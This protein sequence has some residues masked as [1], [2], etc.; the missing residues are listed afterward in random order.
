MNPTRAVA[1]IH[2]IP[3]DEAEPAHRALK[4]L[5]E[6]WHCLPDLWLIRT[7]HRVEEVREF[8]TPHLRSHAVLILEVEGDAAW[9]NLE[10]QAAGW[11]KDNVLTRGASPLARRTSMHAACDD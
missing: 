5:G 8:L 10:R 2:T 6:W 4:S 7:P 3:K 1:I 11:L 9:V